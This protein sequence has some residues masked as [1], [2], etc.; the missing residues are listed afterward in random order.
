[1]ASDGEIDFRWSPLDYFEHVGLGNKWKLSV[2][3]YSVLFGSMPMSSEP[4]VQVKILCRKRKSACSTLMI[5][6]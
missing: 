2:R 5:A 6:T 3:Q 4:V 1:M